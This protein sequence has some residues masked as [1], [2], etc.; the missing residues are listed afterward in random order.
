MLKNRLIFA[1]LNDSGNYCLSRNFYLQAVGDLDWV[2]EYYNLNAIAF[3]IDELIVLNVKRGDKEMHKFAEDI[4]KLTKNFFVPVAAGGGIRKIEDAY[5]L[6][7]SG[8]DKL[9]VNTSIISFPS[10]GPSIPTFFNS[11]ISNYFPSQFQYL[12]LDCINH[13]C[14][15]INLNRLGY[16]KEKY[17][18]KLELN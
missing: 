8:A 5:L 7:N 9:V 14:A 6:L 12:Y 11:L 15:P 1:L 18:W 16:E 4:I 2:K 10:F 17:C 3:S 13:S